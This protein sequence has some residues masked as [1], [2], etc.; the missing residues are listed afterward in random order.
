MEWVRSSTP[1]GDR[2]HKL[3][4][5]QA[6]FYERKSEHAIV[7][8]AEKKRFLYV[9]NTLESKSKST[10]SLLKDS[11]ANELVGCS[12]GLCKYFLQQS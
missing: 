3:D 1:K 10:R 7:L 12:P 4:V 5:N 11:L 2:G 8:Q 9:T 6:R